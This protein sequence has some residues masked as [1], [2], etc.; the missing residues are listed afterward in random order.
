MDNKPTF[1]KLARI[2]RNYSQAR[3]SE[4]IMSYQTKLSR[5][6]LRQICVTDKEARA[7]AE[8]LGVP[9]EKLFDQEGRAL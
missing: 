5:V 8:I 6:E 2:A 9:A 1:L 4:A 7:L 3:L